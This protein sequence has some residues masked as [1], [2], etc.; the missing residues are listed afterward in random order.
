M[1]F[2]VTFITEGNFLYMPDYIANLQCR[3]IEIPYA[4]FVESVEQHVKD[5]GNR[6]DLVF[7][8]RVTTFAK[9]VDVIRKYC[10]SA[11]VLF[12][13]VDIYFVSLQRVILF[14]GVN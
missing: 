14:C 4:P 7:V 1:G 3:S 2:Q 9:H 12:H 5:H 6:Y 10:R 11:K 13:T 8:S